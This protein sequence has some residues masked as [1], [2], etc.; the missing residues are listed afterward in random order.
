MKCKYP[1]DGR[2]NGQAVQ[3]RCGKCLPCR[4]HKRSCWE[5][6]VLLEAQASLSASY[7]T[8]TLADD[9]LMAASEDLRTT[10]QRRFFDALRKSEARSGNLAPIR[11]FGC[12]EYGGQFGRPHWHFLI[13]N[14]IKN[15]ICPEIYRPGFPRHRHHI[16]QW[17]YGHIDVGE[18]N[19]ATIN[20]VADYFIGSAGKADHIS[21]KRVATIQPA[22]GYFG[23]KQL[24]CDHAAR[25]SHLSCAPEFFERGNRKFPVDRFCRNTFLKYYQLAGGVYAPAETPAEKRRRFVLEDAMLEELLTT[26]DHREL[27]R[28]DIAA[29]EK[30][31]ARQKK[32][33]QRERAITARYRRE[34]ERATSILADCD[35][36]DR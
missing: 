29:H 16:S 30:A 9:H 6:R 5:L 24:A 19:P 2:V 23:V 8:L 1:F 20:Y 14:L 3:G 4:I 31:Q 36:E 25:H 12:F 32:K 34:A 22:I 26:Q 18:F 17:P 35:G 28:R 13:F 15:Y 21:P 11:Y 33:D 7:W 27:K 10:T